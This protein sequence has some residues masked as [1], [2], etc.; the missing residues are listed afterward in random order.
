MDPLR[1]LSILLS[2]SIIGSEGWLVKNS[3]N[4]RVT[5]ALISSGGAAEAQGGSLGVFIKES[6]NGALYEQ[7]DHWGNQKIFL[8]Y[9]NKLG[10]RSKPRLP[11]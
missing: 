6:M 2:F 7:Q 3:K 4:G 8:F 10:G 11:G 1:I 9:S 5:V